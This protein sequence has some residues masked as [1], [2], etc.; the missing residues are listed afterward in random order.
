MIFGAHFSN[1]KMTIDEYDTGHDCTFKITF[2]VYGN[3]SVEEAADRYAALDTKNLPEVD[4]RGFRKSDYVFRAKTDIT[5]MITKCRAAFSIL[6]SRHI[7]SIGGRINVC[8]MDKENFTI[9][10]HIIV[11]RGH[12]YT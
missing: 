5:A 12:K 10:N 9:W 6:D 3:M 8:E 4:M 2:E 7:T 1:F 11:Y